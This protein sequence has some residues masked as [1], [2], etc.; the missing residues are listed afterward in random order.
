M[1][2]FNSGKAFFYKLKSFSNYNTWSHARP[3]ISEKFFCLRTK[4]SF[5]FMI[6]TPIAERFYLFHNSGVESRMGLF[7]SKF[8]RIKFLISTID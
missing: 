5:L 3:V 7:F 2:Q 6:R 8:S 4:V 1:G